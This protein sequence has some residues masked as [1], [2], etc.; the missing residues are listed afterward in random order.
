MTL[1]KTD[2]WMGF[3]VS[4]KVVGVGPGMTGLSSIILVTVFKGD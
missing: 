3:S 2:G 4:E 1:L